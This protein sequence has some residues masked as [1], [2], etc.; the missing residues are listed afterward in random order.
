MRIRTRTII[1][2]ASRALQQA[3]GIIVPIVLVRLLTKETVGSYRQVF[4]IYTVL[5]GILSYQL[6]N[7]LFYFLPRISPERRRTLLAQTFLGTFV[8]AS[9]I[10]L[11]TLIAAEPLGRA[12][13][14]PALV[15][16][17]RLVGLYGLG[18]SLAELIPAFMITLDRAVRASVYSILAAVVRIAAIILAFALGGSISTVVLAVVAVQTLV[19]LVGCAD[20]IRLSAGGP[21]RL[22]RGLMREQWDYSWPLWPTALVGTASI[23]FDKLIISRFFD[24][25]VYAIYSCGA[26][27]LPVIGL[28]TISVSSAIMPNLV[29]M[30]SAGRSLEALSV[31]HEATRKCSLAIFPCFAFFMLAAYDFMVLMY[32]RG[33]ADATWPFRI[34]LCMLPLRVAV[35]ATMFRA[36]GQT[37]VIAV[38]AVITLL[39]NVLLSMS[40]AWVGRGSFLSFIGPSIGAVAAAFAGCGY[41]IWR[42]STSL[43][44][45]FRQVMRW[46][47]LGA[48]M[49]VCLAAGALTAMVPLPHGH[50]AI[51]LA[52]NAL[53]FAMILIPLM[54]YL[55]V[56]HKDERELVTFPLRLARGLLF[57]RRR[58]E[59]VQQA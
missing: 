34:Y 28:I 12:F 17:L 9:A 50:V 35:Y 56:L 54:W 46:G 18:D 45:P 55:P 51:R 31:W 16:P 7:S 13:H 37:R 57:G 53:V 2:I 14:N 36:C 52:L 59:A 6:G 49:L 19:M 11:A 43:Q 32:G 25:G 3:V 29:T 58:A 30:A 26:I 47:E 20:M 1:L 10:A 41:Y 8:R 42:L 44:V 39:T 22:D 5:A 38:G 27:E 33:Y 15:Q 48:V 40:L 24:P 4:L 23:Y 21:W